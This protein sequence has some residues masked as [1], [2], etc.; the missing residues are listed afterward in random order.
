MDTYSSAECAKKLKTDLKSGL[1]QNEAK[2]RLRKFGKNQ[3][4]EKRK[5]GIVFLFLQTYMS[6]AEILPSR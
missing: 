3:L 1:S 4:K 5:K 2:K 6:T